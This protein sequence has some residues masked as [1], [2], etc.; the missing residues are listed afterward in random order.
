MNEVPSSEE[1]KQAYFC[2]WLKKWARKWGWII[3]L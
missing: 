3:E 2:V 1:A